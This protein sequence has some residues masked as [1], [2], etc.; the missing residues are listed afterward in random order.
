MRCTEVA[1]R[2][3][4]DEE[5]TCRD[6]GD[7]FVRRLASDFVVLVLSEAVLSLPEPFLLFC[8]LAAEEKNRLATRPL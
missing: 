7:L 2:P 6:I 1:D 8:R 3:L 5:F 4:P